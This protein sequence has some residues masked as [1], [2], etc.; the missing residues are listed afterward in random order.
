MRISDREFWIDLLQQEK[1]PEERWDE[2]LQAIDKSEREPREKT[3]EKLGSLSEAVFAVLDGGGKSEKLEQV[4]DGLRARG[5][6]GFRENRSRDRARPRLLHRDCFRGV[7]SRGKISR[8]RRRRTLRQPHRAV[9][10]RR[11]FV[12]G[13]RICHGRRRSG[14][15][16]CGD[17]GGARTEP[18]RQTHATATSMFTS[19]SRKKNGGRTRSRSCKR[20]ASKNIASI[21][22]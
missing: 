16:D 17:S 7:R 13:G 4:A 1:V 8:A 19:S 3:A 15:I 20:C 9:E 22:R 21:S 12:A 11:C 14:R 10:R 5:L 18:R 6:D 2:M